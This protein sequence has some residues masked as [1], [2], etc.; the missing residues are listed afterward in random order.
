VTTTSDLRHRVTLQ[1]HPVNGDGTPQRDSFGQP[2]LTWNTIATAWAKVEPTSGSETVEGEAVMAQTSYIVTVRYRP[3]I[4]P[5]MRLVYA[6]KP[7]EIQSVIDVEERHFWLEMV[8]TA[9]M[10]QG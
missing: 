7:L 6:G 5:K 2:L 10:T 9:G 1:A 3:G 8:C 4:T